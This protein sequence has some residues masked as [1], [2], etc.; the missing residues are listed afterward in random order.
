MEENY[1]EKEYIEENC[2]E[3][4]YSK[5]DG[6]VQATLVNIYSMAKESGKIV[7][8]NFNP[9]IDTD[10]CIFEIAK[11]AKTIWNFEIQI[12]LPLFKYLILKLKTKDTNIKK[13]RKYIEKKTDVQELK[14]FVAKAYTETTMIYKEIYDAYYNHKLRKEEEND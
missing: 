3:Q 2:E 6:I 5:Y 14:Q 9:N 10:R 8:I 12:D 13:Y 11:I 7:L 4:V 1:T